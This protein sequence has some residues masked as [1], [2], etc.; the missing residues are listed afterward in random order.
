MPSV[1]GKAMVF[2]IGYEAGEVV[3]NMSAGKLAIS[4]FRR[5]K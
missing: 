1:R 4:M 5:I 2:N 3:R